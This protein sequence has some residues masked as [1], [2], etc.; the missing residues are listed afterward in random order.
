MCDL[1]AEIEKVCSPEYPL[2][3]KSKKYS[4]NDDGISKR[5]KS[6]SEGPPL[7]KSEYVHCKNDDR[8]KIINHY[9]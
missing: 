8:N 6:L 5:H 4:K 3:K 9:K 7:A 2:Q 1:K